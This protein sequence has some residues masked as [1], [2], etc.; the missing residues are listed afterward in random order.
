[1][2]DRIKSEMLPYAEE[3][4]EAGR[5]GFRRVVNLPYEG[6]QWTVK[7][8]QRDPF[9]NGLISTL[10]ERLGSFQL[11]RRLYSQDRLV[12]RSEVLGAELVFRRRGSLGAFYKRQ[13]MSPEP[14]L[15]DEPPRVHSSSDD[16]YRQVAIVWDLPRYDADREISGVVPFH[17][18][19]AREGTTLEDCD[20]EDDFSLSAEDR[21]LPTDLGFD[22]DVD[23][24]EVEDQDT[25]DQ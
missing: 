4:Q 19:L 9:L 15:F 17:V 16:S 20:W 12:Y 1:M 18:Y 5:E 14:G 7:H 3:F 11:D 8:L 22:Q 25:N 24:W 23:D 6:A 10:P 2:I 13:P 21:F